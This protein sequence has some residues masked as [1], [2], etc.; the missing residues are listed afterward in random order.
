MAQI[1]AKVLESVNRPGRVGV[2]A[3]ANAQGAPN[4]AYFG[5]P[6]L[7][8]DGTLL[9]GLMANR[10]LANLEQ[11]PLAVFFVVEEAPVAFT[12]PGYRL[13]LKVKQ[14]DKAGELLT[15]LRQAVAAKAGQQTAD[16]MQAAVLF[17]VTEVRSLVAPV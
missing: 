14:I 6:Q 12:T 4:A 9:M 10:S 16:A 15:N 17:E 11:N 13:Y 8:A 5:T 3:T 7:M 2:L 1:E